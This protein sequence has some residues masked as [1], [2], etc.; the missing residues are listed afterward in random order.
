MIGLKIKVGGLLQAEKRIQ[1]LGIS[2]K[3][4]GAE[5]V[6]NTAIEVN[7]LAKLFCPVDTG[8]LRSS[9]Q[10]VEFNPQAP[11]AVVGT[12]VEYAEYVEFGTS[13]QSAQPYMRPA[14][15]EGEKI[16]EDEAKKE[17][18]KI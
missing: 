2:I 8:R 17:L 18:K 7:R 15:L 14:A 4:A 11:S 10:I 1:G 12:D 6:R 16:L 5:A 13:R 3:G 9:I